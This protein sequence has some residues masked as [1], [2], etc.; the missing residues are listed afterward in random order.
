MR[1]HSHTLQKKTLLRLKSAHSCAQQETT[2][3]C[4]LYLVAVLIYAY[5]LASKKHMCTANH[6]SKVDELWIDFFLLVE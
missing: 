4:V 1:P 5:F 2:R 6:Q 3:S